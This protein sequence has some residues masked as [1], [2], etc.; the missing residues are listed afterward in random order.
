MP[1]LEAT[2][3]NTTHFLPSRGSQSKGADLNINVLDAILS[4]CACMEHV[5][6][7]PLTAIILRHSKSLTLTDFGLDI[8]MK[9]LSGIQ[10][11]IPST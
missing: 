3:M 4:C 5:V 11:V 2:H 10:R 8:N 7:M 9:V 1:G 6:V